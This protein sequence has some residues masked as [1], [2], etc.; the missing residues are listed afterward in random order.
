MLLT[1]ERMPI[2][3]QRLKTLS[4]Q[5]QKNA[6]LD[7]AGNGVYSTSR[8]HAFIVQSV[9][10][11][12]KIELRSCCVGCQLF[13]ISRKETAE[14]TVNCTAQSEL[15]AATA[16][17]TLF[18]VEL[19]EGIAAILENSEYLEYFSQLTKSVVDDLAYTRKATLIKSSVSVTGIALWR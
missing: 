16:N 3:E 6:V 12:A 18:F 1:L 8:S 14:K 7:M 17:S 10:E 11:V 4:C 2:W 5:F 9:E 13:V 19:K 15:S